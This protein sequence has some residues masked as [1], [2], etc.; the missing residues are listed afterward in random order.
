MVGPTS[1]GLKIKVN[2][3][4]EIFK[5][6]QIATEMRLGEVFCQYLGH[7]PPGFIKWYTTMGIKN[8][9]ALGNTVDRFLTSNT[10]LI[11]SSFYVLKIEYGWFLY[12]SWSFMT[13]PT[14]IYGCLEWQ[15]IYIMFLRMLLRSEFQLEFWSHHLLF[16]LEKLK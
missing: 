13:W 10:P 15:C 5:I 11:H 1:S 7:V 8:I 4:L 16:W 2:P 12:S 3:S 14:Y 6:I 9:L